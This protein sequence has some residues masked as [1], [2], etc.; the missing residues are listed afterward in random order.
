MTTFPNV[1]VALQQRVRLGDAREREA[2]LHTGGDGAAGEQRD[3]LGGRS[4]A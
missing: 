1:G 4:G 2:R 3:H